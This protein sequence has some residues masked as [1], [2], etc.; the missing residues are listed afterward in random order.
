M[1]SWRIS[2]KTLSAETHLKTW[3]LVQEWSGKSRRYAL[4]ETQAGSGVPGFASNESLDR[5]SGK[6]GFLSGYL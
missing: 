1:M 6:I 2:L 4:D 3:A 5:G